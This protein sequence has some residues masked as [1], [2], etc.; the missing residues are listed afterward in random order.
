[1]NL[2]RP[3]LVCI[4]PA[5][6]SRPVQ[7]SG[8]IRLTKPAVSSISFGSSLIRLG[9]VSLIRLKRKPVGSNLI[10]LGFRSFLVCI[11]LVTLSGQVW[12]TGQIRLWRC[13]LF[14]GVMWACGA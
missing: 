2:T 4:R 12:S 14:I 6:H 8:V 13:A 9:F 1:M 7:S 10:R 3:P 11:R 5:T